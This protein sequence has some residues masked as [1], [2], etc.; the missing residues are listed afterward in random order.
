VYTLPRG[1]IQPSFGEASADTRI[2]VAAA[3]TAERLRGSPYV[4]GVRWDEVARIARDA[5]R[6][7]H[8]LDDELIEVIDRAWKLSV[9]P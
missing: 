3:I 2:A 7:D 6:P 1:A 8:P 9:E 5:R 4:A